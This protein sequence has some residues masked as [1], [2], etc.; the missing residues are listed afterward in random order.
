[1]RESR[2]RGRGKSVKPGENGGP[3]SIWYFAE[4]L[5]N[6]QHFCISVTGAASS[7][8]HPLHLVFV[9]VPAR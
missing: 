2:E 5:E 9:I 7:S 1:M 8:E 3:Q 6:L 4:H